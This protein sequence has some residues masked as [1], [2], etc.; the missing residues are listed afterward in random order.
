MAALRSKHDLRSTIKHWKYISNDI[1]VPL[2][3]ADYEKLASILDSLLDIAGENES[4][5]LIGLIDVISH[6]LAM[7]D[8]RKKYRLK[9]QSGV[10]ALKY[11]MDQHKLT[12]S[13]LPEVGSQGVVSE[14]LNGKRKLNL[15]QI[16][17]LAK[18][19]HVSPATFI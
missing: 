12:Q 11:L 9:G 14:I 17:K 8:E 3:K 7:Y 5:E 10:N 6:M 4:H 18:K 13:D 19:F 1:H 16:K 2:N 15:N